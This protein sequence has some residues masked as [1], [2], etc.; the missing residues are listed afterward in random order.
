MLLSSVLTNI[1]AVLDPWFELMGGKMQGILVL[2]VGAFVVFDALVIA[3]L[4]VR[5]NKK[6]KSKKKAAP[7]V[8]EQPA[9]QPAVQTQPV[10][11]VI[12]MAA[13][14]PQPQVIHK[15]VVQPERKH[16]QPAAPQPAVAQQPVAAPAPVMQPA[17]MMQHACPMMQQQ[18]M[19]MMP[20]CPAMQQQISQMQG[21]PAMQQQMGYGMG[22]PYGQM[23]T[24]NFA[25][26]MLASMLG[27]MN[28]QPVHITVNQAPTGEAVVQ[29]QRPMQQPMVSMQPQMQSQMQPQMQTMMNSPFQPQSPVQVTVNQAPQMDAMAEQQMARQRQIYV[30]PTTFDSMPNQM[31]ARP[32][33]VR[34]G[35]GGY[36]DDHR[37]TVK[38]H[39]I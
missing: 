17:P 22:M 15:T 21:C 20:T 4:L 6:T 27:L 29:E 12:P 5:R 25:Q 35:Q 31:Q 26:Q 36:M 14:A 3:I 33:Y 7:V 10:A 16:E 18:V 28:Q 2:A 30:R 24:P 19:P 9:Q 11:P 1:S 13:P 37:K 32:V 38:I 34:P 8:I 23:F 39:Q